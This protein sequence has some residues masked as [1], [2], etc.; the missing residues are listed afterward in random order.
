MLTI[1]KRLA[2]YNSVANRGSFAENSRMGARV[3]TSPE[4]TIQSGTG[5]S[6]AGTARRVLLVVGEGQFDTYPLAPGTLVIGRDPGCDVSLRHPKI[7]R[8][9]AYLHIGATVEVEDLGSTNG[10]RLAGQRVAEGERIFLEAGKSLQLGPF[11]AVVLG[12]TGEETPDEPIRAAIAITD[13]TPGGVPE[14]VTRVAAGTVSVLITGE[15]GVGKEILAR[16]IHQLSGR[17]GEFVAINCASLSESLLESELFGHERGSFTGAAAAKRGLFEVASGGTVFLDE[18]GE[19]PAGLQAKLL[20]VLETRMVYRVGGV[21]PVSLDVRFLAA[22]HRNL[23]DEVHGGAFRRDLY[24]R[25]NGIS[26]AIVPLRARRD[27][28]PG[29]ARELLAKVVAPGRTPPRLAGSAL[30]CL[31]RHDWPGNVRELRTVMERAAVVCD[32]D[33]I[34][35]A[36]ILF[37]ESGGRAAVRPAPAPAVDDSPRYAPATQP[38]APG[39]DDERERIISA[40]AEC[41][42][43]QTHAARKLGISRTTLVH[44]LAVYRIPRPRKRGV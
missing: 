23:A 17:T 11:V 21:K 27:A 6:L 18:I 25:V 13:P 39:E 28:I 4:T 31:L 20:R 1:V 41:A 9:H 29:L 37:D 24:F 33:E 36:H 44:K 7:S 5:T 22:T 35:A 34:R 14:V 12:S 30:D 26:L 2:E 19:L 3:P 16:T 40:L 15:T 10:T 43:N 38:A 42:G 8:R 32:S